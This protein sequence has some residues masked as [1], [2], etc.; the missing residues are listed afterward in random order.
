M[1]WLPL[2]L[3]VA[4]LAALSV[5]AAPRHYIGPEGRY[6]GAIDGP[7]PSADAIEVPGPPDHA[8]Y[9]RWDGTKWVDIPSRAEAQATDEVASLIDGDRRM[10]LLFELMLDQ[11]NRLRALENRLPM[12]RPAYRETFKAA[13]GGLP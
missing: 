12:T 8:G 4:A 13:I 2:V 5:Q 6:I 9:Q 11:E 10:R 1:K 7:A 3:A